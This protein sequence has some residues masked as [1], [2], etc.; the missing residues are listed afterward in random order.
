[1]TKKVLWKIAAVILLLSLIHACRTESITEQTNN[2]S[3]IRTSNFSSKTIKLDESPHKA[4][5]SG[6]L[7][8]T[9]KMLSK[10]TPSGALGKSVSY[11][12]SV[13][14]NTDQVIF[15][16]NGNYH[17]YIFKIEKKNPAIGD[18]IDNL[19]LSPLPDG[20]YQEYLVQ[21]YLTEQEVQLFEGGN[22]QI[23]QSK[24]KTTKIAPGT[25]NNGQLMQSMSL[26]NCQMVFVN[27]YYTSCSANEHH[28]G[29]KL[30]SEGGPCKATTPSVFVIV[31]EERCESIDDNPPPGYNP[32]F[33]GGN[34]G[35]GSGGNTICNMCPT[36]PPCVQLPTDPNQPSTGI[37]DDG[38]T[39]GLPIMP[40]FSLGFMSFVNSLPANLYNVFNSQ[41]GGDFA[42]GLNDYY[43]ANNGSQ[44]AKDFI[45]W[46]LQF[47]IQNPNTSWKQFNSWFLGKNEGIDGDYD[48][49]FW[50]N[51]NL[52]FPQQILPT[53]SA[54]E[55]A[56]PK[57]NDPAFDSPE[58]M[59]Q[60]AGSGI[61]NEYLTKGYR[62]TCALRISYAIN[63]I[64]GSD[65]KPL[66]KIPAS[67]GFLGDDGNYYF[68][69]AIA[70]SKWMKK[71]FGTPVSPYYITGSQGGL[72]G[73]NFPNLINNLPNN[74]GIYIMIPNIP[75][76]C[77]T[78]TTPATGFCA[79]GHA[80]M[81]SNGIIDGGG[82]F[83]ATGG[84]K[85][86]FIWQLN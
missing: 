60:A 77:A 63:H 73:V 41:I 70:L 85:E 40:N 82:Y 24:I 76:G 8:E 81:M 4:K 31:Y 35:G 49:T 9:K 11:G 6:I 28:N 59:Y 44:Q 29:E 3:Q 18:P 52:S 66:I 42:A 22:W 47:I 65:G 27:S 32:I 23:P 79:S 21:Y 55:A 53:W 54:F 37:G 57:H 67:A 45:T 19:L 20:N 64:L 51:P 71:T 58:K 15:I 14:I 62:N 1:M 43:T 38:C 61:Y 86:I 26:Q 13:T 16:Q 36:N 50:D 34:T 10:H 17:N 39:I 56:Y 75:G 68:L 33:P 25:Y 84:V 83:N 69:S 30:V 7:A 48:S 12:D 78:S 46:A 74:N 72:N 5:L 80:D 2:V